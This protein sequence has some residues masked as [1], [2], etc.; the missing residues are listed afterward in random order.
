MVSQPLP[1]TCC[2][3]PPTVWLSSGHAA[4]IGPSLQ[5]D[6]HSGSVDCFALGLDAP[7][8]L[9]SGDGLERR[10]R[11]ALIPARTRHQVVAGDG[12][13]MFF[14]VDPGAAGSRN[15]LGEMNDRTTR[16]AYDHRDERELIA[17]CQD[18]APHPEQLR[19]SLV[20]VAEDPIDERINK[21]MGI[22]RTRPGDQLSANEIAEAV[23]LSTSRFLHLFSAHAGTSF[24]RYRQWAR[25]CHVADALSKGA[26]LTTAASDAGFA[27]PSHF[28]DA[29]RTMFGLTATA[30]LSGST[31]IVVR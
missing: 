3:A 14:Y 9:R 11:S 7:F 17:A 31:R 2:E 24:R 12:R 4:Y 15:L 18:A 19:R 1:E 26:D 29:F 16:I 10:A 30:L 21:A 8:T 25:M 23:G 5:L 6:A 28:S 27:S 13:M 20:G 22:L